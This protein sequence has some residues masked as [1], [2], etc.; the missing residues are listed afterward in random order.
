MGGTMHGTGE[1]DGPPI[2]VGSPIRDLGTGMWTVQGS[3]P[4]EGD[5][6]G[7]NGGLLA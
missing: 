6:R 2:S 5:T 7:G 3:S 4:L 1:P